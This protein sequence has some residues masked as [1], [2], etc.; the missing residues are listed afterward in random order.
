MKKLFYLLLAFTTISLTSCESVDSK[1]RGVEV[2]WGGETNMNKVYEPG[3]HTGFK[4]LTSELV[5]YDVSQQ[6]ITE[7]FEFNDKNSMVTPVEI[8]VDFSL[9]ETK[10]PLLHTKITDWKAKLHS[11][12]KGA[13]KQVIPQFPAV[14]LNLSKR[15]TAE[16][17]IADI[18]SRELPEFYL[19]FDRIRITDVDL[20]GSISQTAELN[21][22]QDELNKLSS[23]KKLEAENN[24]HAAEWDAKTKDILSQ[25]SMLKLKELEIDMEYARKGVSKYGNNNVFGS[26]GGI[27]LNR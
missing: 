24:F 8:S 19:V 23:K 4:W 6:T 14:D 7:K 25:P 1:E 15:D 11:T 10:V 9:D 13:A 5:N 20:P 18:L 12:M 26:A 27:L 16:Q 3:M 22:K 2:S 21:A 17:L